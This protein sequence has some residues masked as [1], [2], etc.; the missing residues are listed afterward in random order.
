MPSTN[1]N[2]RT[3]AYLGPE[4]TYSHEAA[5]AFTAV[6]KGES[7]L[8]ECASITEIFDLVDRGRADF[9]VVPIENALDMYLLF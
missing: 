6:D 5:R 8:V 3:Y 1:S 4:G 9:G 2:T 7:K